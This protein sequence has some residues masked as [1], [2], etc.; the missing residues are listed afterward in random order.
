MPRAITPRTSL[1]KEEAAYQERGM[2]R[3]SREES[4]SDVK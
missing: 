3:G 1:V 2:E 4:V